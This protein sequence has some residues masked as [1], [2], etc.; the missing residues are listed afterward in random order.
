L[1]NCTRSGCSGP[2]AETAPF[3]PCAEIAP[4]PVR[5]QQAHQ[6]LEREQVAF[7]R[8]VPE[9]RG[10]SDLAQAQALEHLLLRDAAEAPGLVSLASAEAPISV[11]NSCSHQG[12]LSAVRR[13]MRLRES[14]PQASVAEIAAS[15]A[16]SV[17]WPD[18]L[19][20]QRRNTERPPR[21]ATPRSVHVRAHRAS[22]R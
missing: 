19:L 21:A 7:A 2:S 6:R 14:G 9:Q 17:G 4:G 15:A 16:A 3:A 12:K 8:R 20:S 1:F 11:P 13:E 10:E 5:E 22:R 18:R